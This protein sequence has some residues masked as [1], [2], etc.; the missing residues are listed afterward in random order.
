MTYSRLPA[1]LHL[2]SKTRSCSNKCRR[3]TSSHEFTCSH[4]TLESRSRS[5][6]SFS[7]SLLQSPSF[8]IETHNIA[9]QHAHDTRDEALVAKPRPGELRKSRQFL[10][11]PHKSL[12]YNA[13]AL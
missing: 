7:H 3:L 8:F 6:S 4:H 13:I 1:P 10:P 12:T 11:K 2:R 9:Q 5:P